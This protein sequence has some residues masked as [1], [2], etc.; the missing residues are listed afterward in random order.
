MVVLSSESAGLVRAA[1]GDSSRTQ[2]TP[3]CPRT[4]PSS[5]F[6]EVRT[7]SATGRVPLPS[8]HLLRKRCTESSRC[9]RSGPGLSHSCRTPTL[10]IASALRVRCPRF[11]GEG[12]GAHC[13]AGACLSRRAPDGTVLLLSLARSRGPAS[14]APAWDGAWVYQPAP[15]SPCE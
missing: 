2:G 1:P 6:P 7:P 9:A 5:E 13:W 14:C 11:T 15:W 8:S 10:L 3:G 12:S 4:D